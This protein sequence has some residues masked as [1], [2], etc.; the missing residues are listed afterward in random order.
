MVMRKEREREA[1]R[2]EIRW[3]F[4]MHCH[5]AT[6]ASHSLFMGSSELNAGERIERCTDLVVESLQLQSVLYL[7]AIVVELN[8]GMKTR[9]TFINP[10]LLGSGKGS[11]QPGQ[12]NL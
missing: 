2:E 1:R 9:R 10:R 5:E 4:I 8:R 11:G 3:R 12:R 6:F 7:A